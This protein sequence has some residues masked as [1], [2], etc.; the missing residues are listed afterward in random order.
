MLR[1]TILAIAAAATLGAAALSP[2][3][4]RLVGASRLARLVSWLG[5]PAR[6]SCFRG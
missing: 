3:R 1:K 6:Y 2:T 5:L 4:I